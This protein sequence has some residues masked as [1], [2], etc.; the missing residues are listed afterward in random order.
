MNKIAH[1]LNWATGLAVSTLLLFL[2]ACQPLSDSG[3]PVAEASGPDLESTAVNEGPVGPLPTPVPTRAAYSPGELVPYEAQ[4]GDMLP[5]LAVRFNTTVAEIL[6]ANPIIPESVKTL[7]PGLPMQI[8]IYFRSLWGSAYRILPDSLFVNGP[9]QISFDTQAFLSEAPGWLNGHVE[10]AAGANRSSAEIVDLVA[11]NFSLSPQLLLALLEYRSGA[12]SQPVPDAAAR[13]YPLANPER[14]RRG[15]YLQ[16]VWAADLLNDGYYRWR[17]GR[18]IEFEL[19]DG[20][21]E[22]PDPWQ[23]AATVALQHFFAS[24]DPPEAYQLAVSPEGFS[25]T[26]TGLFGDPWPETEPHIPGSL[27]QPELALP[28]EF[29]RTWA[30][31]G[32]PHTAWGQG[33]PWAALDF[34]PPAVAGGCQKSDEW[35]TAAAPG[36]VARSETGTV[37]LD[38]DGDGDERTG[39]VLFYFHIASE[40]RAAAGATLSTGGRV[41]HPSCEGGRATGSHIH[42]ARK[43]NGEWIHADGPLAFNLGGWVSASSGAVYKGTMRRFERTIVACECANQESQLAHKSE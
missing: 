39:W 31:T 21:L 22:R 14:A 12:L 23:N 43:Y 8:P 30:L 25:A 10:Y 9:A 5:A 3:I 16:L 17:N 15:L 27:E 24:Q 7:P 11:L 42:L 41:G 28:F 2:A 38:L 18:L 35:A 4:T 19:L 29:G 1:G 13:T 40:G 20:R 37:V 6:Q 34:A 33:E 32:G 36:V 26:Y